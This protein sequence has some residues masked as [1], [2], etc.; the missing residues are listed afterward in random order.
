MYNQVSDY[1][2]N[3]KSE[4][5]QISVER[6]KELEELTGYLRECR[7]SGKK[8]NL[9]FVCT[10]NSRR[11]HLSQLW[12][13]VAAAYYGLEN[14]ET[15]SGGTERTAFNARAVAAIER[16]GLKTSIASQ[17]EN[18]VYLVSF[19]EDIEPQKCFSK[20][21]SDSPNPKD[22]FCAVMTCSSADKSCPNVAGAV[23][24]IAI[25]Y[26]DPKVADDTA[27]EKS[28]YDER[29]A[30]ICRELLYAFSIVR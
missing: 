16:A 25:T 17:G 5:G 21:F 27:E 6:R 13:A 4:F 2:E 23:K 15:F 11:S 18:P 28:K 12:A 26:D 7:S 19:A 3:R 29:S 10:H 30:Q 20:L 9:V 22:N 14:V 1:I 24:R 8:A